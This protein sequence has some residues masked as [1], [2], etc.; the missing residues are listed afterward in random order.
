MAE[1]DFSWFKVLSFFGATALAVLCF[2]LLGFGIGNITVH[3]VACVIAGVLSGIAA[4]LVY[5]NYQ[6][7]SRE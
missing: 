4:V 7:K 3:G 5:R 1:C 2:I 6:K